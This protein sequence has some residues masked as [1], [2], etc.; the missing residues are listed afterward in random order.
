MQKTKQPVTLVVLDGWGIAPPS[1]GNAV[2][3]AKTPVMD[4]LIATYPT[5]A[6]QAA[7]E[8]VGLSWG[9][10]GNSEV[11]H[12]NLGSG[13]IIYQ[14]LPR[15]NKEIAEGTFFKNP[16]FLQAAKIVNKNKSSLHLIGMVSN[17][18]VHS[19]Q[20]HLYALL[21][22]C[23]RNKI[24]NVFIHAI[25]DGR[26]SKKDGSKFFLEQLNEKIKETGTGVIA[27]LCGRFYAMDRN[28][29]WDRTE[30]AY[31]AMAEGAAENKAEDALAAVD[32]SYKKG[33][34]DEEFLPTVIVKN[35]K[36]EAVIAEKDAVIFFNFRSDRA[37]Q[38]TAAFVLPGFAKFSRTSLK[39]LFF[40]CMMEYEKD[41][42]CEVV[43]PPQHIL[44]PLARVLQDKNLKQVH[45]AETE[46]Y[47]HVTF[48]FN[49]GKEDVFRGE[50]RILVPS[51]AVPTYD[52]KPEMSAVSI[53]D[54]LIEAATGKKYD[55]TIVNFANADMVGHTGIKEA[56]VKAVETV[57]ACLGRY[58]KVLLSQDGIAII[59]ADHGNAEELINLQTGEVDKEH[60][61]NP[62]PF[63][64]VGNKFEGKASEFGNEAISRDL[65]II[66]PSGLLSDVA[67][68][69]LK[70]MGIKQPQD[71]TGSPLL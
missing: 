26:D 44:Y 21:E 18:G 54:K 55:F 10:M 34:Y 29:N 33:I 62:V 35:G 46:K 70:I 1:E 47:A 56:T 64:V 36:P 20:D 15:I 27:S 40:V 31:R 58:L 52:Q 17:G 2:S 22:L 53:T 8:A 38:L 24:K 23:K 57:D 42:P 19:H 65:S 63:I 39:N 71:M 4:K 67:P 49:G 9:E 28:N 14:S 6:L 61:T 41:L 59:T 12:L 30:K 32:E 50:D 16:V 37:R 60:S 68:T 5:M 69:I 7:G 66:S 13:K 45:V 25:L 51:P 43:F 11:G 3:E 48:F